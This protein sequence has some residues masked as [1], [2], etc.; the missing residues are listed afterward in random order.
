MQKFGF[1]KKEHYRRLFEA[2]ETDQWEDE[3]DTV[4]TVMED[5]QGLLDYS[6]LLGINPLQ[7]L[8]K[9]LPQYQWRYYRLKNGG[10]HDGYIKEVV[11][12]SDFIWRIW[13]DTDEVQLVT[14]TKLDRI[15]RKKL[16]WVESVSKV[17][18][19]V[20]AE[21]FGAEAVYWE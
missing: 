9:I 17:V 15:D 12:K 19:V 18:Q 10:P 20:F 4:H 5:V 21:D 13:Y 1:E 3:G 2:M 7:N 11:S 8:R 16:F 14:A 6:Y